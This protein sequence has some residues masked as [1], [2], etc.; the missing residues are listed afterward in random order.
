MATKY[1]TWAQPVHHSI[2]RRIGNNF[3]FIKKLAGD[4]VKV[5]YSIVANKRR[6]LGKKSKKKFG[7]AIVPEKLL[8]IV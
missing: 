6:R 5:R 1:M 2:R 3:I 4:R 7:T 8:K